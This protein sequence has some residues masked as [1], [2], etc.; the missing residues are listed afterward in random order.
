MTNTLFA[1]LNILAKPPGDLIYHLIINLLLLLS[2]V[3]ALNNWLK[4]NKDHRMRYYLIGFCILLVLQLGFF[5][6]R[7][8]N[9]PLN[10]R[11]AHFYPLVERLVAT[12]T[13]IGLIW[14]LLDNYQDFV[15]TNFYI[16]LSVILIVLAFV[17][18]AANPRIIYLSIFNPFFVDYIWQAIPLIIAI[19]GLF[20][21][22][23]ISPIKVEIMIIILVLIASGHIAQILLAEQMR[24]YMG[25]VRLSQLVTFPWLLVLTRT[26]PVSKTQPQP[27]AIK[28]TAKHQK[29]IAKANPVIEKTITKFNTTK[30]AVSKRI[31]SMTH[32][33][34]K[35]K[36]QESQPRAEL[37]RIK[38]EPPTNTKTALVNQLLRVKLSHAEDDR[39]QALVQALSL[40]V[41]A[42]ICLLTNILK[43]SGKV[44]IVSGYDLI[45]EV[46]IQPE[47]LVFEDL[48]RIMNAWKENQVL[49]L[50][51]E[52]STPR[53]MT[54]LASILKLHSAGNLFAYPLAL[55]EHPLAGGVIFL[56][57]YTGKRWGD[58][59]QIMMDEIKDT[60]AQILFKPD[61]YEQTRLSTDEVEE[62][63]NDMIKEINIL[64]M[65]I[66]EKEAQ[67]SEKENI[68][69]GLKAKYQIDKMESVSKIEQMKR[70]IS[71][72][73]S[74]AVKAPDNGSGL[75]QL[76]NEIRQLLDER[77]QLRAAL[78][79]ANSIIKDRQIESGQTGPIRLSLESQVI[80]L[81][82]VAAN[83]RLRV[84]SQ[85]QDKNIL[86]E[87]H[88]P[89]GRQMIKTDPELL[90]TALFELLKNACMVS[91]H[92]GT[93]RLEQQLSLEMGLLIVQV[94][95]FGEGLTHS[96]QTALFSA[97]H[98]VI[99]GIGDVQ[100]IRSAIRAIRVLNGKIWL[101]SEKGSFTTFRFQIPV[102][103]ID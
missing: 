34:S 83:V 95:D 67:I 88:N 17:S 52:I 38:A 80:S 39:N 65:H 28:P 90:Q 29:K 19:L 11:T 40:Y 79:H 7:S 59:T 101:K 78:N 9:T 31:K 94:T 45:R 33:A 37:E 10:F 55:P 61:P 57:P 92:G 30:S 51:P 13:I 54:T 23:Y 6:L 81:D 89:D 8:F 99:A 77:E 93:I 41:V 50:S 36:V 20:L 15:P 35:P 26:L 14:T 74:P 27:V 76:Q 5:G 71:E 63:M 91:K 103:I 48:P 21:A 43:K 66:A 85:I 68:I 32:K 72:L 75:E 70:R 84:S 69:K 64:H 86:L 47:E 42:D 46:A 87:I 73:T 97:Q 25:A 98:E 18:I 53:D 3:F 82:S 58:N 56:S 2:V 49:H 22:F 24:W 44:H 96:E 12:L 16:T 60:L 62:R 100:A 1:F 4:S 102:R